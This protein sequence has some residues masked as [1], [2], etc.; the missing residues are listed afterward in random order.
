MTN[1]RNLKR[2]AAPLCAVIFA[3]FEATCVFGACAAPHYRIERTLADN[4]S[5]AL[6][7]VSIR[8]E[9][10]VP[11][12]L[13][14]LARALREKYPGRD[15]MARVFSSRDAALGYTSSTETPGH[16]Q[17]ES[18]LHAVY[19]YQQHP[20]KDYV[21]ILPDGND[22]GVDDFDTL[23][24]LP[25]K[26]VPT[27]K[28][29]VN[30]RCLLEFQHIYYPDSEDR[31]YYPGSEDRKEIA[32]RVN[33]SG[34]IRRD[35][36]VSDL[37][38]VDA[39]VDPPQRQSVLVDSAMHNLSTWR[40]QPAK[41]QDGIR[42]TYDFAVTNSPLV[43][44]EHD[45]E[46][47]LP[48]E[49]RIW[50]LGAVLRQSATVVS[51]TPSSGAG[52][53]QAFTFLISHPA[54]FRAVSQVGFHFY[55]DSGS[56]QCWGYVKTGANAA[57]L[58]DDTQSEWLGPM[59]LNASGSLQN[60]VCSIDSA[61]SSVTGSGNNLSLALSF[62]FQPAFAGAQRIFLYTTAGQRRSPEVQVATW[63]VP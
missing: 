33:I 4:A 34:S 43:G 63:T 32:G 7:H 17:Y 5:G 12:K 35:G 52:R 49:V 41:H 16:V 47:Q 29:A 11:E 38:V 37:V 60:N 3:L 9:D 53:T 25:A 24:E 1:H 58:W 14:C 30:G 21:V 45:V 48:K 22:R 56:G 39:K 44:Y 31:K 6:I 62:T 40:F 57:Y 54:D 28:L 42:I 50:S 36:V 59:T 8:L 10:F 15:L 23:V 51:S 13:I 26:G 2:K 55:P 19:F 61:G 46:F 27:C 20:H 18:K